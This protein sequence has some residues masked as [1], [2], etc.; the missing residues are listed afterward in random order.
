MAVIIT[1]ITYVDIV[2]IFPGLLIR[3]C[4]SM[5]WINRKMKQ[6]KED[7]IYARRKTRQAKTKGGEVYVSIPLNETAV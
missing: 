1:I 6:S 7:Y 4:L 2:K 5:W 3:L